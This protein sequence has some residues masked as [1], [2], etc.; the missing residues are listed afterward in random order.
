MLI[1][2]SLCRRCNHPKITRLA[3]VQAKSVQF[4][5]YSSAITIGENG[6]LPA[7]QSS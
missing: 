1:L 5:G 6:H 3:P 2:R 7:Y 4:A